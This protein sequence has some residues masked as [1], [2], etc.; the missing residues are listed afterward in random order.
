MNETLEQMA[1]AI[2]KS[3]FVDFEPVRAK[4]S[5]RWK[6]GESL[7]GL[8]AH[9]WDLFPDRL[10]PSELG[11]I[12]A[13]W[14]SGKV[15]DLLQE[16]ISGSRP[17]GGAI[18]EGVPSVG[19]ENILGLGQY[20][21]T[22]EKFVP[23]DFFQKLKSKHADVRPGDVL[24]YKDGAQIGRKSYFDCGFPHNICA[25]NEHVFILRTKRPQQQH[26]L[27]FWLDQEW[28]TNEIILLNSSSAQPGIN[29]HGVRS[30]PILIIPD[31]LIDA[32]DE[33]VK[34]PLNKLFI[35][36]KENRLLSNLRDILLTMLINRK[37]R[38]DDGEYQ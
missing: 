23:V 13:G 18:S 25:V 35:N 29:Q 8:P 31:K 5:G 22:K 10:V 30:L 4:M 32:F 38:I 36:C 1:R 2:F 7:P 17:K 37:L 27:Y 20:D 16:I 6:R 26:Y 34:K 3:W 24:L 28:L 12:P 9:L 21:F 19:A 11:D 33:I 15:K 14:R